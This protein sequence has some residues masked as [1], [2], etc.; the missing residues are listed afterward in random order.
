MKTKGLP[1]NKAKS[2][3]I[4]VILALLVIVVVV[5]VM[6]VSGMESRKTVEVI[7][8][9]KNVSMNAPITDESIVSEKMYYK[10]FEKAGLQKMSN[11]KSRRAIILWSER[12]KIV[13]KTFASYYLRQGLPMYW[14]MVVKEQPKKHSYLYKLDGELLNINMNAVEFGEM[15]V[16]GDMLN[17]RVRYSETVYDLPSEEQYL[18]TK[19]NRGT[20]TNLTREKQE[21][22]FNEV[23]VLDMLNS[24]G[25]SIFDIYYDFLAK[26]KA[27]QVTMINNKDFLKSVKPASILLSVTAEEAD[28]FMFISGKSP[29]FLLTL[30][31]RTGNNVILES[32]ADIDKAAKNDSKSTQSSSN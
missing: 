12:T 27:T 24:D 17:I 13:G 11:G 8:L 19:D 3:V 15:V 16:P 22:L 5:V 30:L 29:R 21:M 28:R 18:L 9:K 7:K 23:K 1:S 32:L 25:K 26:P 6:F 4:G 10:E 2:Q 20:S 14:D 31:P